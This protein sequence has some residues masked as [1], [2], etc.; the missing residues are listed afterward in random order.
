MPPRLSTW[1]FPA[2]L[3][4]RRLS[5]KFL[6]PWCLPGC[7]P[8]SLVPPRLSNESFPASLVPP[9]LSNWSFPA[10]LVPPGASLVP[11]RLLSCLPGASLVPPKLSNRSFPASLPASSGLPLTARG[12]S[13]AGCPN[14]PFLPPCWC[15]VPRG[16]SFSS[17]V[18]PRLST[19]QMVLSC[20]PGASLRDDAD[21]P[22]SRHGWAPRPAVQPGRSVK[23][24]LAECL[25]PPGLSK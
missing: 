13:L 10:S 11:R 21:R 9:R 2:S 16:L 5:N 24:S 17:L 12:A 1:S 22:G 25:E 4:P 3:V 18:P 14:G 6:P 20:L 23:F 19:I 7:Y 8:A 15:L